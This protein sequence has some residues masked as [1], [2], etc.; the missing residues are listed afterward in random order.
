MEKGL[1]SVVRKHLCLPQQYCEEWAND[2][3]FPGVNNIQYFDQAVKN[4]LRTDRGSFNDVVPS[5][6]CGKQLW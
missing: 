5:T 3:F 1:W 4:T 2:I 6:A